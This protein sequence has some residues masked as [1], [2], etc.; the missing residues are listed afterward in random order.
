VKEKCLLLPHLQHY[1]SKRKKEKKES[2]AT[3]GRTQ[4]SKGGAQRS[5]FYPCF[6]VGLELTFAA[7]FYS[8][9]TNNLQRIFFF[10]CGFDRCGW[11]RVNA[12]K[13]ACG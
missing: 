9:W 2:P 13:S 6:F 3:S 1:F 12:G 8:F 11:L 4:K 7:L 10:N 5:S